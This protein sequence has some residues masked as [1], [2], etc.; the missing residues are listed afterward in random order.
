MRKGVRQSFKK[1]SY[2]K[3]FKTRTRKDKNNKLNKLKRGGSEKVKCCMCNKKML[4]KE[5]LIPRVCLEKH[6]IKAHRIC[7]HC[8]WD[9]KDGF[10]RETGRHRCP[11]CEKGSTLTKINEYS[12]IIDLTGE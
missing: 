2:K 3:N 6:G 7:Q 9:E 1:K 10:A 11:G 8:W 12:E 4:L 5:S